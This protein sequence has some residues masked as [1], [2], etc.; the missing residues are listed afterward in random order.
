M[1]QDSGNNHNI[2]LKKNTIQWLWH[3]HKNR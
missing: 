2:R 3:F 1:T